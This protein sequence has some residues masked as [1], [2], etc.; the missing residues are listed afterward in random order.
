MED[1]KLAAKRDL[2]TKFFDYG[3]KEVKHIVSVDPLLGAVI[4][5]IGHLY[6][7][8]IPNLFPA[9]IYNI[10]S[11]LVSLKG[12]ETVWGKMLERFGEITPGN[13]SLFSADQIQQCGMTMKKAVCISEVSIL[14]V[15][16]ELDL[17][18]FENLS[19]EEV[20]AQLTKIKGI[21]RWT[22]E[23][24]LILSMERPD[25]VS[26]GDLA[27]RKGMEKLYGIEKISK[28]QFDKYKSVYSPYGSV[29]S[30]Y[31]WEISHLQEDLWKTIE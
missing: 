26:F 11:Q 16:K 18:N 15:K 14:V 31:F 5:R 7:E 27:I 10:V 12:A 17:D 29:A 4:S 9:L 20:V 24:I 28:A 2:Q 21:G 25:V 22:G 30:I 8:V 13:L 19:D 6:R 1:L 23:M 3:E